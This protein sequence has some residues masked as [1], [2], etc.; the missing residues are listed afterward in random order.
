MSILSVQSI[1][2]TGLT[3][4]NPSVIYILTSDTYAQVTA[5]GYLNLEKQNGFTFNN[6]QMALVYTTDDGPVWLKVVITYS[7]SS[8]LSTVVS[9]VQIT[10]P[11]DVILPTV[12]GEMASYTD[13]AGTLSGNQANVT[14]STTT[15]SATPGTIRSV[16]GAI[17]GTNTTMTS[18]N[19]VGVRGVATIVGAS[20]GFVYGVQ[21]KVLSSGILSGSV[22]AAA[23]F[24]QYDI[25]GA[26]IN[27]GQLAPLWGDF[28][29]TSG[30]ITNATGVRGVTITNTTA[31]VINA[32]DYRYGNSTYLLEL[33]GAGGTLNYY[34]AAGT[35]AGSAGDATHCAAQQVIKIE[36]NGVAAYIPVFTQNT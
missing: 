10:S 21:G 20:G 12:A 27:Q 35:S 9:L 17:S 2:P 1:Q 7:N 6:Q 8:I 15:S 36:V 13:T 14:N 22:W 18:G 16:I 4:V 32:Q 23:V 30:T 34:A 3:S 25:S 5:T 19:L 24:G 29:A 26:T 28:G 31:M 11:G 33:A